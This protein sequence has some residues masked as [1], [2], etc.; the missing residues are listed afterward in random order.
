MQ[1]G[2]RASRSFPLVTTRVEANV[3]TEGDRALGTGLYNGAVVVWAGLIVDMVFC[4][5]EGCDGVIMV[6]MNQWYL[7]VDKTYWL[8]RLPVCL[9]LAKN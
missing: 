3:F 6:T 4:S 7:N 9:L 1:C 5:G 8:G 2:I